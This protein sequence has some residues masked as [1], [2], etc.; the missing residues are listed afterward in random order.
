MLTKTTSCYDGQRVRS[1][2]SRLV[3]ALMLL[4]ATITATPGRAEP[5]APGTSAL[6]PPRNFDLVIAHGH[7]VDGTGSPWYSGDVGIRGG[8]IAAIG[9][10]ERES[11]A[12]TVDAHG[13][14]VAPG[15]IDMLG[16]SPARSPA[17]ETP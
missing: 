13:L 11:R 14:V 8:R 16:Q 2:A 6:E 7:I 4:A 10:L 15:F 12:R 1:L 9:H 3:G 5:A 17:K